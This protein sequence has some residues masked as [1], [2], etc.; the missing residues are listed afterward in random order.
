MDVLAW[1]RG[2]GFG[3]YDAAFRKKEIDATVLASLTQKT[4]NLPDITKKHD[5]CSDERQ[6][7]YD[8]RLGERALD[9]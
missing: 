1:L 7:S 9:F 8:D 3:K 6:S 5:R 4:R 2:L